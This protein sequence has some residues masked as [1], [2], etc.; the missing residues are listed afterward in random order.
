MEQT[1]MTW[2]R[3]YWAAWLII[4]LVTFLAPEIT[5][6][7]TGHPENTLSNYVWVKLHIVRGEKVRQWTAGDFLTFC[8]WMSMWAWLTWH[9]FF[10]LFT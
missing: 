4:V 8:A 5:A 7:I 2:G 9:F 1:A 3:Q 10:G 6:L